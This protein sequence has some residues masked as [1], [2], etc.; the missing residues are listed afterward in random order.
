MGYSDD[1]SRAAVGIVFA[2]DEAKGLSFILP[3][4]NLLARLSVTLVSGH[5]VP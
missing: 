3:L 5:N 1:G 4:P 2:G